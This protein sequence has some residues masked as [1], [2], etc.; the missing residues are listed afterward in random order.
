M[1]FIKFKLK[2]RDWSLQLEG[3][4]VLCEVHT[5]AVALSLWTYFIPNSHISLPRS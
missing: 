2:L 3:D 5:E 1:P 4:R